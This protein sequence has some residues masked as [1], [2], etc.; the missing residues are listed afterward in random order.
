VD[1]FLSLPATAGFFLAVQPG[2][3]QESRRDKK[4]AHGGLSIYS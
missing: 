3:L 4:P 1:L 2:G